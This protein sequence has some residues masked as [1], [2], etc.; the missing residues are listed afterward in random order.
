MKKTIDSGIKYKNINKNFSLASIAKDF[1]GKVRTNYAFL[2][3]SSVFSAC[4]VTKVIKIL[5]GRYRPIFFEA[6]GDTGFSPFSIDWAFNSMPSGHTAATF[7]G[8]VMVGMLA[9]RVKPITW[10]LAII[11]GFSRIYI[12]AHWPTDVILGAFIGMVVADLVKWWAFRR[13]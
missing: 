10:T 7:A 4:I 12:G 8:L 13:K 6:L 5:L 11:V 9:P 2:I 1:I 3:F